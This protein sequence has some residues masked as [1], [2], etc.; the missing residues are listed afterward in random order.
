MN[1]TTIF[2]LI[3][4]IYTSSPLRL[5]HQVLP[6]L[7]DRTTVF[8]QQLALSQKQIRTN[9]ST[10]SVSTMMSPILTRTSSTLPKVTLESNGLARGNSS[11]SPRKS[12]VRL[13]KDN[14]S[15]EERALPS[16]SKLRSPLVVSVLL[17]EDYST[18]DLSGKAFV[19]ASIFPSDLS[20]NFAI[21]VQLVR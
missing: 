1:N 6:P 19:L 18:A 7:S 13:L 8:S 16:Y 12:S 21:A 4:Y 9:H 17:L 11:S 14:G 10:S 20:F 15:C 5:P 2:H 3:F